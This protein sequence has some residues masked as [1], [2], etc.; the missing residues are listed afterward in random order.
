MRHSL[1]GASGETMQHVTV[2]LPGKTSP[3]TTVPLSMAQASALLRQPVIV[4]TVMVRI[5][6]VELR[7]KDVVSQAIYSPQTSSMVYRGAAEHHAGQ[8][9]SSLSCLTKS[10]WLIIGVVSSHIGRI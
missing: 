5:L 1:L 10:A 4:S 6:Q 2:L 3:G 9:E 8:S 7:S